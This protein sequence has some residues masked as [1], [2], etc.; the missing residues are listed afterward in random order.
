MPHARAASR[1]THHV[2]ERKRATADADLRIRQLTGAD[3]KPHHWDAFYSFY[4]NTSDRKWGTP[5]LTRDFFHQLGERMADRV[6]LVVADSKAGAHAT[7]L[8]LT[9]R[10]TFQGR[11]LIP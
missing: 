10:M 9:D 3:I 2:Q 1:A 4:L 6:L 7:H 8:G 5:Y 11:Q